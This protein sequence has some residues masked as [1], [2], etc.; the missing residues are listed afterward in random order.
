MKY[1]G[2]LF[3]FVVIPLAA[4]TFIA[5]RDKQRGKGLPETFKGVAPEATL[6]GLATVAVAYTTPWDN[7][8]VATRVWWYDPKLVTGIVF[9]WVPLEEYTF[10]VLQTLLTGSW[11]LFL[12]RHLPVNE[13]KP[14]NP[15][16]IRLGMT[17]ALGVIWARALYGFVKGGKSRT[18]LSITLAW[19]LIPIMIQT[20]FGGDILWQHRRLVALG[21][22]P[23]S[24]YLSAAD[25]LAIEGGT[26][27]INPEKSVNFKIGGKLPFEEALFFFVTNTLISMG[28]TLVLAKDSQQRAPAW[29]LRLLR[30]RRS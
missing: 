18:Y 4:L 26:W 20:L 17:A 30:I 28:V 10:F 6:A 25:S 27:T 13:R 23:T 24:I 9:G 15:L 14:K 11:M 8:L 5:W 22:I 19:A 3:R 2:F 29:L 7:Y 12:A 21:I 16:L 1:F